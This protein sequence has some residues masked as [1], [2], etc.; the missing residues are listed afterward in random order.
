MHKRSTTFSD[1]DPVTLQLMAICD[2][3]KGMVKKE[4]TK[5]SS[6]VGDHT[7]TILVT[8]RLQLLHTQKTLLVLKML[9]QMLMTIALVGR[10]LLVNLILSF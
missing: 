5:W 6:V 10:R 2:H 7:A 8:R 3:R 1:V 9:A 4:V